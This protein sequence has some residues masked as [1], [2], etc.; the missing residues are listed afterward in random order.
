MQ[1]WCHSQWCLS[2][3]CDKRWT[4]KQ[5]FCL[6]SRLCPRQRSPDSIGGGGRSGTVC[7]Q[8]VQ[9]RCLRK[10][11]LL[12]SSSW[13]GETKA[14][15]AASHMGAVTGGSA[16]AVKDWHREETSPG[17]TPG[18]GGLFG[19]PSFC[20]RLCG[21]FG[22]VLAAELRNWCTV[23]VAGPVV[24]TPGFPSLFSEFKLMFKQLRQ[25]L[26]FLIFFFEQSKSTH[27]HCCL[28]RVSVLPSVGLGQ[29]R[30][31]R[32]ARLWGVWMENLHPP[33]QHHPCKREEAFWA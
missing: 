7:S 19:G 25:T 23:T 4:W 15:A 9:V 12:A 6:W 3:L 27:L 8:Q 18:F 11:G 29:S 14:Q 24:Q 2:I 13:E 28:W 33:G 17:F 30:E 5:I 21:G 32:S 22:W 10:A 31:D 20:R 16:V 1:R 26:L